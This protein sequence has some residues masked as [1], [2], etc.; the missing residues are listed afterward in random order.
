MREMPGAIECAGAADSPRQQKPSEWRMY[1][2]GAAILAGL[3]QSW[4]FRHVMSS[5]G[6]SYLDIASNCVRGDWHSLVNGYWSP[7]YPLLLGL[8]FRALKPTPYWESTVAHLV[9]FVIFILAFI[10]FEAFLKALIRGHHRNMNGEG[11]RNPPPQ[12]ALWALGDSLFVFYTL[13]FIGLQLVQPDLCVAALVYLAAALLLRIR[14]G[15]SRW[16]TY[17][18]LGTALGV[19]YLAKEVMFPLAFAFLGCCLFAAKPLRRS[20]PRTAVALVFFLLLGSPL[21]LALSAAKGRITFGDA[22]KIAYA[23]FVDGT[24]RYIHWQGGPD[25][26]G[27]PVHPTRMLLSKPPLFEFAT[28]IKG[29]YPPWYDP[30]YWYE[31]IVPAFKLRNQLRAIRCAIEEYAGVLPYMV[32]YLLPLQGLR[33]S[34]SRRDPHEKIFSINGRSG[35]PRRL[36]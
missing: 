19:A 29:T 22:G 15:D 14:A 3:L 30:S 5:D 6:V 16:L 18:G 24:V 4:A 36:H 32:G 1:L 26:R 31:G 21:L 23:E 7:L 28:P 11:G 33:Y 2:W 17:A 12:W 25:G 8:V 20:I 27:S 34:L 10:S 9:N 13:L 35:F